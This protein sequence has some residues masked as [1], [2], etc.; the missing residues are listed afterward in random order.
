MRTHDVEILF[1]PLKQTGTEPVSL[2]QP[3]KSYTV[4]SCYIYDLQYSKHC[5]TTFFPVQPTW[6]QMKPFDLSSLFPTLTTFLPAFPPHQRP[7]IFNSPF[8]LEP[9][10]MELVLQQVR[11]HQ[12]N[13]L[14][15]QGRSNPL[16]MAL[17]VTPS[18]HGTQG[19][20]TFKA[21]HLGGYC[22]PPLPPIGNK[23]KQVRPQQTELQLKW[24]EEKN[25]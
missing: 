12:P 5:Y 24:E 16:G 19:S 8:R 10:E 25:C 1:L 7:G 22:R 14:A 15:T 13:R 21:P 23:K 6:K 3:L 11:Y 17:P 18:L 20:P 9:H 4:F 2:I